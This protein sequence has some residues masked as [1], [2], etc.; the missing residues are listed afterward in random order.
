M[1]IQYLLQ[2]S[3]IQNVCLLFPQGNTS[4][5]KITD[6]SKKWGNQKF[7]QH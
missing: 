3:S 5:P 2:M 6:V 1:N 4:K 7:D